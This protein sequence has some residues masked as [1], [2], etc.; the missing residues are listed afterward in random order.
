MIRLEF[1]IELKYEIAYASDLIF[2]IHAA[3]T[4]WHAPVLP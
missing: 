3:R 1:S 4:R 2:S